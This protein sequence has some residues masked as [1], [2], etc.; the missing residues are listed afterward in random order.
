MKTAP[1]DQYIEE[2]KE[3]VVM[4]RAIANGDREA[5]AGI[6]RRHADAPIRV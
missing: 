4:L 2:Q 1:N 6:N 3:E 5:F